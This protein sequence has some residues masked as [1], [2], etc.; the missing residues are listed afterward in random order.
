[1]YELQKTIKVGGVEYKIRNDADFRTILDCIAAMGDT[2]LNNEERCISLLTIFY[3][4]INTIEDI[5]K[6]NDVQEAI[7]SAIKFINLNDVDV[8]YQS[9]HKLLDWHKDE[10][11]IV[12]AVNNVAKMEIRALEYLHWWT[13]IAYY[14]AIGDCALA[15]IISIRKKILNGKKLDDSEK[16]FRKQNPQYFNWQSESIEQQMIEKQID[17]MWITK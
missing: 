3:E 15:N 6:L 11:M 16:E 4:D 9:H 2:D 12:S 17:D 8:G 7:N 5:Y 13:F 1:M 10:H 14:M